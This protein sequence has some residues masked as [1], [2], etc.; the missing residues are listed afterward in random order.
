LRSLRA[1]L[2]ANL[3]EVVIIVIEDYVPPR[4]LAAAFAESGLDALVYRG[5]VRPPWPTLQ[6]IGAS[7]QRAVVFIES[8]T[9][10]VNWLHPAFEA[11]QETPY[12]FRTPSEFTCAPNRGGTTGSLF[13]L[14]HWVDTAPTPRPSNAAL[15][16]AYDFLLKR[17]ET[18]ARERSRLPNI[19]AVDFY[20]TGD[21][22]QVVK[23]LNGL[24]ARR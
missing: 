13:L 1:F 4:A 14:N 20:R 19:I 18:C 7:G 23:R 22:F 8:G 21:L 12:R 16:N 2:A 3:S 15:V 24:D 9:P 5:A 6:E 17:A 11:L 10:G